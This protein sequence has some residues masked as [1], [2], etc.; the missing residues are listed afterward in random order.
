MPGFFA[1]LYTEE[2]NMFAHLTAWPGHLR[3]TEIGYQEAERQ[4]NTY[5]QEIIESFASNNL[6]QFLHLIDSLVAQVGTDDLNAVSINIDIIARLIRENA[7]EWLAI[8]I[9][10]IP[11]QFEHLKKFAGNF[12]G[13]LYLVTR[14]LAS[15]VG[16]SWI[17]RGDLTL[18]REACKALLWMSGEEFGGAELEQV[19]KLASLRDS[20]I[21]NMLTCPGRHLKRLERSFP[22]EAITVL[23][24][25]A[26]RCDHSVL[27]NI[28]MLLEEP[29]GRHD[30]LVLTN[31]SVDDLRELALS[32]VRLNDLDTG[33]LYHIEGMLRRLFRLNPNAWLEF[34]EARI[35]RER[36]E[37]TK[38][39]YSAT[40]FHLSTE[41]DYVISSGHRVKVLRIF[42]EWSARDEGAYKHNG[43]RLLKLYSGGQSSATKDI[44]DEWLES[45]EI[46]K[47]RS[48]AR[49]LNEMGYSQYFLEMARKL[50][51]KTDDEL[52]QAYLQSTVGST[53]V[54]SGSLKPIW[55]ARRADFEK[56][57]KDP[58]L[59]ITARLF[60]RQQIEYLLK[61]EELHGG[62]NWEGD[63]IR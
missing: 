42:L 61:S 47:L 31:V 51:D 49:V 7:P 59:S 12:L 46:T 38:G 58:D 4:H 56:W 32:F 44:L 55:Q 8:S 13:E 11:I 23:K 33:Y 14:K 57:L 43:A 41:S 24:N 53:G 30:N 37:A 25:I 50:L 1:E 27:Q 22:N 60:A 34:W 40:P 45:G 35:K 54:V 26:D 19:K 3:D 63:Y 48:V 18:Q 15:A 36:D 6:G 10:E 9:D 5:W 2:V 17:Q 52:A 28:A 29:D 21:D 39:K 62:E 20:F 16:D